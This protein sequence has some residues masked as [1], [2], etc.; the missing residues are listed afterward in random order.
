MLFLSY[1][2]RNWS[3]EEHWDWT[4]ILWGLSPIFPKRDK[5]IS[6]HERKA[7]SLH[8]YVTAQLPNL[9]LHLSTSLTV[10]TPSQ[11]FTGEK[12]TRFRRC[13]ILELEHFYIR[14]LFSIS[15]VKEA[16]WMLW[17]QFYRWGV[18]ETGVP[19]AGGLC[20]EGHIQMLYPVLCHPKLWEQRGT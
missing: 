20:S 6:F 18:W 4:S 15:A 5:M 8:P 2:N 19:A 10:W 13:S 12:T 3:P 14:F 7:G 17:F 11:L 1:R 9:S 16:S